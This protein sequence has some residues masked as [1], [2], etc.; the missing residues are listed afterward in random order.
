M[1]SLTRGL[2][3]LSLCVRGR[4]GLNRVQLKKKG[5]GKVL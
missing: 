1:L 4:Q 2:Y 3:R 5:P